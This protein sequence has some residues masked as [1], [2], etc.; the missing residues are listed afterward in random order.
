VGRCTSKDRAMSAM[1]S[2]ASYPR[3][4]RSASISVRRR[5]GCRIDETPSS[6][7]DPISSQPLP[8]RRLWK[9]SRTARLGALLVVVFTTLYVPIGNCRLV[10]ATGPTPR[11]VTG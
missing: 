9:G 8:S 7:R 6:E 11:A 2:P 1:V 4:A 3:T 5:F 10:H